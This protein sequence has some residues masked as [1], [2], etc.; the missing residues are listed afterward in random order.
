[1]QQVLGLAQFVDVG[2]EGEHDAD[3]PERAGADEGA[4]LRLEHRQG[5]EAVADGAEAEEGVAL[6][7][8][9]LGLGVFVGAEVDGADDEWAS[10]GELDR[11]AVGV[12][13]VLFGG[14][15]GAGEVEVLGA[16]E[17]DTIGAAFDG[18]GDLF[19]EL[20]VGEQGDGGAVGGDAGELDE[21]GEGELGGGA[22]LD[23]A[24][25]FGESGFIG[26]DDDDAVLSVDDD[27]G[28]V[29]GD[30]GEV[31]DAD[32]GGDSQRA[33]EDRGVAGFAAEVGG[34]GGDVAAVEG[35]CLK[36]GK[37]SRDDD[38]AAVEDGHAAG[39]FADQVLEHA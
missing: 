18:D 5:L 38:G 30:I 36:K 6:G 29:G 21:L 26:V 3:G 8:I 2:D 31:T 14:L 13:V 33:G 1:V 37:V 20:D 35:S 15:F 24:A 23:S 28:L 25:I 10:G 19:G 39:V 12:V 4:E 7:L 27:R 34:E 22:L 17:A 32:D 16:V 11:L 9:E